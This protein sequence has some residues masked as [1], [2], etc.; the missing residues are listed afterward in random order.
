MSSLMRWS[1]LVVLVAPAL[2]E[3]GSQDSAEHTRLA[4]EMRRLAARNAWRGVEAAYEKMLALEKR[5]VVLTFDDH[6]I[7]A[8]SA[9]N[10]GDI[11]GTYARVKRARE[12]A[13]PG[14][15]TQQASTWLD[16]INANYGA[17]ELRIAPKY[18]GEIAFQI[19]QMPF[20]PEH[21]A[22]YDRARQQVLAGTDYTGLLPLGSYTFGTETFSIA[23][24]GGSEPQRYTLRA[25]DSGG[26]GGGG[27]AFGPR[28]DLGGL[29]SATAARDEGVTTFAG[30][31]GVRAGAGVEVLLG[32]RLGALLE[33][34]YHG[35]FI[36]DGETI[37][38][39]G[40]SVEFSGGNTGGVAQR[41]TAGYVWVA[42]PG[43]PLPALAVELG[44]TYTLGSIQLQT[45]E[46]YALSGRFTAAGVSGGVTL[47]PP[48]WSLGSTGFGLSALGGMQNDN[49]RSYRWGLA[50]LTLTPARRDG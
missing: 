16:D 32:G 45:E 8:Q 35:V 50:A 1:P 43:R 20:N 25:P 28:L 42:G 34:G 15:Q 14:E 39:A 7:A 11:N 3:A 30:S 6:F 41:L 22:V 19:D 47:A 27:I 49:E 2:A 13:A 44:P 38:E 33:V 23:A 48:S 10:L 46:F 31:P 24:G 9:S 18:E 36:G 29:L 26:G 12:V 4:E 5:G 40:V 37:D 21:R 17:V